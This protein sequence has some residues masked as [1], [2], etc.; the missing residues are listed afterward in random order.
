MRKFTQKAM[1]MSN[2]S[3]NAVDNGYCIRWDGNREGREYIDLTALNAGMLYKV[4]DMVLSAEKLVGGFGSFT[5]SGVP[6]H[7]MLDITQD[8]VLVTG[9]FSVVAA[10]NLICVISG[11][12]GDHSY[13]GDFPL[14]VSIPS[15][16]TY[17]YWD[18][19]Q[20]EMYTDLLC[21]PGT[22]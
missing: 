16:G 9:D 18:K 11:R 10:S 22:A 15:D 5:A 8:M 2:V 19:N 13:T 20:F 21:H 7:S 1:I 6:H 14:P 17:F 3:H 12:A 4:S